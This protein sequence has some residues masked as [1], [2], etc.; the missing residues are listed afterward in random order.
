MDA[1][2]DVFGTQI[3]WSYLSILDAL[4]NLN[5]DFQVAKAKSQDID[6]ILRTTTSEILLFSILGLIVPLIS[7]LLAYWAFKTRYKKKIDDFEKK[8]EEPNFVEDS[9]ILALTQPTNKDNN[10][11]YRDGYIG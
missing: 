7:F 6:S 11:R 1:F 2:H 5:T 3:T 10:T 4:E 9:H 8:Q